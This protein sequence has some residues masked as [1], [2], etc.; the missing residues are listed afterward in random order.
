LARERRARTHKPTPQPTNPQKKTK[1]SHLPQVIGVVGSGQMGSGIAQVCA[2][3][4]M[5]VILSDRT[6]DAL[7]HGLSA[8]KRSLGRFVKKGSMSAE[9][10]SEAAGRIRLE[11]GLEAMREADFVV[12]AVTENEAVKK[13]VFEEL[14]RTTPVHAILASNTSSISITKLAA[15]T[16]KPH[17]VCGFHFMN[18]VPIMKLVELTKGAHTSQAT[19]ESAKGLAE[20]LGKVTVV[21]QDRPVSRI[22]FFFRRVA[23]H[24]ETPARARFR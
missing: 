6:R 12:E 7:D 2:T 10:A 11:A 15:A 8:I 16:A 19:F 1:N 9:Q 3:R 23:P 4:G 13:R 5:Q 17:R 22:V 21:S 24:R 20:A 18:P 14:D